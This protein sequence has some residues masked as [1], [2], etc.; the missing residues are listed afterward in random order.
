MTDPTTAA[1]A[2]P[3]PGA[4]R[5]SVLRKR[6]FSTLALWAAVVGTLATGFAPGILF[7]NAVVSLAGLYEF[8]RMLECG[9]LACDRRSGMIAG[10]AFFALGSPLLY[11]YP[12]VRSDEFELAFLSL[13]LLALG[14]RQLALTAAP[15]PGIMVS[16]AHTIFGLLYVPWLMNY[17]AKIFFLAPQP[18]P[19]GGPSGVFYVFYLLL[20]TKFSDMGAYLVGSAIGR[21][22]MIP[23]ISPG[24]T[25]EGFA[26][27]LVA[28]ALISLLAVWL[29]PTQLA[30]IG[31]WNALVLGFS[32]GLVAVLGDLV[33]SL[34]K[35]A[36]CIKDSGALLP[37]IGGILDL[38]DSVLFTA[39]LLYLYLRFT[40]P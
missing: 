33:E 36:T 11:F 14:I 29:F 37:G 10:L 1:A 13:A 2:P 26:G 35:R 12:A 28:S 8:Y 38:I 7:F 17:L 16:L 15:H 40:I 9:G 24:K 39:P 27:A 3:C 34:L 30:P 25:W 4:S 32:L 5:A 22:K 19:A 20:V 31:G 18:A 6:T 21:H 23:R